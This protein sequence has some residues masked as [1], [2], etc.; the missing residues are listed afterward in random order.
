MAISF[1]VGSVLNEKCWDIQGPS[2]RSSDV[3][4]NKHI[5]SILCLEDLC[6][7]QGFCLVQLYRLLGIG[8]YVIDVMGS[9]FILLSIW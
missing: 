5:E 7:I 8:C 3:F 2:L 6:Q 1:S 9:V 4:T